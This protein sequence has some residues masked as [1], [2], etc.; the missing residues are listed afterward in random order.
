MGPVDH[1]EREDGFV[2]SREIVARMTEAQRQVALDHGCAFFD[3]LA[4]MGGKG[5]ITRW[6]SQGLMSGDLSHPTPRGHK[7][8]GSMLYEAVMAGYIEYRQQKA[9]SPMPIADQAPR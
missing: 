9:G 4:A 6:K 7:L 1:G 5:A 8:L 3:T 2:R